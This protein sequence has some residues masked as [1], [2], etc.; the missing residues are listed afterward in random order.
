MQP[1][2]PQELEMNPLFATVSNGINEKIDMAF[3][4]ENSRR[5]YKSMIAGGAVMANAIVF[6]CEGVKQAW[7]EGDEAKAAALIRFAAMS[8]LSQTFI[9]LDDQKKEGDETPS[10]NLTAVANTLSFFDDSS[11]ESIKDFLNFDTQLRHEISHQTDMTHLKALML[12]AAC[13]ACGRNCVDW[14]KVKFPVKSME[15]LTRS[16]AIKDSTIISGI[17]DIR[18]L[19]ICRSMGIQAMVQCHE[20]QADC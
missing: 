1:S 19:W 13:E 8:M 14:D 18:A 17:N 9:W 5:F 3:T 4:D 11:A 10:I 7:G 6:F 15:P 16:G 12:A 2:K 20:E